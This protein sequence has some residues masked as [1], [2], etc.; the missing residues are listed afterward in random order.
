M[1]NRLSEEGVKDSINAEFHEGNTLSC[2]LI[3][4]GDLIAVARFETIVQFECNGL[5]EFALLC[6]CST[7]LELWQ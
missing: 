4:K 2:H 6:Q 5:A 7:S 3:Y 1:S